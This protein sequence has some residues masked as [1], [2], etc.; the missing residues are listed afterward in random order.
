MDFHAGDRTSAALYSIPGAD[1]RRAV[2]LDTRTSCKAERPRSTA[3]FGSVHRTVLRHATKVKQKPKR[4]KEHGGFPWHVLSLDWQ[5][6]W[7]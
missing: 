3:A 4:K 1:K 5:A 7:Y 2:P 6:V